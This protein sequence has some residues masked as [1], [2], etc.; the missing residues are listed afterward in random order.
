MIAHRT[1][2]ASITAL[3]S[4]QVVVRHE[5]LREEAQA[6]TSRFL[7]PA[8]VINVTES[9]IYHGAGGIHIVSVT[10]WYREDEHS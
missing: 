10:V 3:T 1:F 2:A 9:A 5:E 6:F 7:A 4:Q 8:R